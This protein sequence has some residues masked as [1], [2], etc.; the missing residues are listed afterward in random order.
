MLQE[1]DL[2]GS[3]TLIFPVRHVGV[4][5]AR[6]GKTKTLVGEGEPGALGAR[7]FTMAG[8]VKVA[9]TAQQ[10][11]RKTPTLVLRGHRRATLVLPCYPG[12]RAGRSPTP[13]RL[14]LSHRPV[15]H[16]A[17]TRELSA[18]SRGKGDGAPNE[19]QRAGPSCSG[20]MGGSAVAVEII[21]N[22]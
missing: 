14:R 22:T 2:V 6:A 3:W 1:G 4:A 9:T 10:D 5:V 7:M 19:G 21:N 16:A 20:H 18:R 11:P 8:S 17:F 13:T 15:R 12:R